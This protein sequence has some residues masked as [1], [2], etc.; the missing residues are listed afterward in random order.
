[1]TN[2]SLKNGYNIY[3]VLDNIIVAR[4]FTFYQ[5]ANIAIKEIPKLIDT[6]NCKVQVIVVDLLNTIL[7]SSSSTSN[8]VI[9]N[10][11]NY[12]S[13]KKLYENANLLKEIIDNL[14][15]LSDRH[16]VIVSYNDS[17]NLKERIVISKFKNVLEIDQIEYIIKEKKIGK[18]KTKS[19]LK[20]NP[21]DNYFTYI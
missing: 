8:N 1:M 20:I 17:N 11:N 21:M 10:N 3:K 16:F 5:L 14:I 6:L 9:K 15:N 13:N 4:A 19:Q 2:K 12:K 18:S 7:S